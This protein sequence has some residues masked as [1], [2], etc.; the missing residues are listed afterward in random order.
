MQ[1]I[2]DKAGL[3]AKASIMAIIDSEPYDLYHRQL[4]LVTIL[5]SERTQKKGKAA[6]DFRGGD[7]ALIYF[8]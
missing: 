5:Q 1:I 3:F 8:R 2:E 7:S 6:N 4:L